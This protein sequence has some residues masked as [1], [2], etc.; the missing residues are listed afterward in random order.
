LSLMSMNKKDWVE[1]R[2]FAGFRI[3]AMAGIFLGCVGLA[4]N[5]A[6]SWSAF[7]PSYLNAFLAS[8]VVKPVILIAASFLLNTVSSPMARRMARRFTRS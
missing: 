8:T 4:F 5:L 6:D 3:I 2:L 1:A 7:D